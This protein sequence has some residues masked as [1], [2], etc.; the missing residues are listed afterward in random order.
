LQDGHVLSHL[1]AYRPDVGEDGRVFLVRPVGEVESEDIHAC[2]YQLTQDLR[3][4]RGRANGRHNFR[5]VQRRFNYIRVGHINLSLPTT[6]YFLTA[7]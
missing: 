7:K 5:P 4:P 1:S 3:R 2:R 6:H